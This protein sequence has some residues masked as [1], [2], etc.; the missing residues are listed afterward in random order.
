MCV[1]QK[2]PQIILKILKPTTTARNTNNPMEKHRHDLNKQF[3]KRKLQGLT[4]T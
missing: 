3:L 2:I 4:N 1:S